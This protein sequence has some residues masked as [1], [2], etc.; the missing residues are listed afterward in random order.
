ML[1]DSLTEWGNWHELVPEHRII[2][3]GIAGDTSSGV[4]DRLQE[5]I[6]RRPKVVFVMIGTNDIGL[7]SVDFLPESGGV[8]SEY[9]AASRMVTASM[10]ARASAGVR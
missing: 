4:L 5:V 2:N 9:H 3:R 7:Q 1:G 10:L 8:R 6:E